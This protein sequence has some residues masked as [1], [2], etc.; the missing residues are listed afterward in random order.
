LTL[1]TA[2]AGW[3]VRECGNLEAHPLVGWAPSDDSSVGG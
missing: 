2:P 1:Q 3:Q